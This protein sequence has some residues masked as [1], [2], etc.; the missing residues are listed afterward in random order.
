MLDTNIIIYIIKQQP[1]SVAQ[2]FAECRQGEVVI[3]AVTLAE[4][5]YGVSKS[6]EETQKQNRQAL[7]ALVK[8]I[9]AIPFGQSAAKA[10]AAVRVAAPER[11]RD[12]LDR[13][14]ASHAISLDLTL[15]TNNLSDFRMYPGITLENWIEDS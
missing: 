3:S 15:V 6:S 14:I 1:P 8:I 5:E 12:A 2:R 4:L 9:P 7:D 11:K 10:Y 13:L